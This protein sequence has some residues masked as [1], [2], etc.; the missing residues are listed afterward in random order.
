MSLVP[1]LG[2]FGGTTGGTIKKIGSG[3]NVTTTPATGEPNA[4]GEGHGQ[5]SGPGGP[6]RRVWVGLGTVVSLLRV[7]QHTHH[8]AQ[9]EAWFSIFTVLKAHTFT[10]IGV[11]VSNAISNTTIR[12]G[13]YT[14]T[15]SVAPASLIHD[16]GTVPSTANG[17]QTVAHTL[18]LTPGRYWLACVRQGSGAT[19]G[20]TVYNW[21]AVANL[22]AGQMIGLRTIPSNT[23]T[24]TGGGGRARRQPSPGHFPQ[25]LR[26]YQPRAPPSP[27]S[28]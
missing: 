5:C 4:T 13:I 18:T 6:R 15:G 11:H 28:F 23:S 27:P 7:C 8:N 2:S 21:Q 24:L 17:P 26:R 1:P 12:L 3:T 14:D 9:G 20:L 16:Y 25:Q 19:A 10:N 22:W